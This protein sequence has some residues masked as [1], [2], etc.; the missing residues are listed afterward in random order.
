MIKSLPYLFCIFTFLGFSQDFSRLTY[1]SDDVAETSGLIFFSDRLI[2]HN[3]S[4]GMNA[5]YEINSESGNVMRTV[6]ISNAAN[7]DWEDICHDDAFIYIGDFG[8]NNGDRKNL[9]VYKI[10]K[11]DYLNS[12]R[13]TAQIIDFSYADQNDF[14]SSPNNTNFDAEALIAFESDL[15]IFTK[16]WVDQRTNIYKLPKIPGTYEIQRIDEFNPSGLITGG[17]FNSDS[18]K[19]LLTGYSG[20]RAFLIELSG[21]SNGIFSNG[22]IEK[23]NLSIPLTESFQT[24]AITFSDAAQHYI[25]AEKNALG[26]A[27]LYSLIAETLSVEDYDLVSNKVFPN[28]AR[29]FLNV[30]GE[31]VSGKIE[32][33]SLLGEKVFEQ[34]IINTKPLDISRLSRGIYILKLSNE[35]R[36]ESFKFIKE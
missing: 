30:N 12:D 7:V 24:E 14:E 1:L 28:P 5:L 33:F 25:S 29:D 36:S 34:V 4:G 21:F 6:E 22:D 19:V 32:I 20:I 10:S 9:R 11:A 17:T 26:D 27:A 8:N 3:D 31:F 13:V 16:N 18:N 23:N 35:K 2:T 15:Y